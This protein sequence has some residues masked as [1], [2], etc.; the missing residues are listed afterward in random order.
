MVADGTSRRAMT[1]GEPA[2]V[3][4]WPA[5]IAADATGVPWYRCESNNPGEAAC[6]AEGGHVPTGAGDELRPRQGAHTGH[7]ED[8]FRA[9]E[10]PEPSRDSRLAPTRRRLAGPERRFASMPL[11]GGDLVRRWAL[12]SR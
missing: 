9:T 12:R 11:S 5:H 6:A 10:F 1:G 3:A 4:M 8:R 2:V 7:A